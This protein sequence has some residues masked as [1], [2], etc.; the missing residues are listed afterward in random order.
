RRR[1]R[2]RQPLWGALRR[3]FHEPAGDVNRDPVAEAREAMQS[4]ALL[5]LEL[6]YAEEGLTPAER[7]EVEAHLRERWGLEPRVVPEAVHP[8]RTQLQTYRSR[9]IEH[10]AHE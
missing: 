5:L 10:F 3:A 7:L 2:G 9:I 6:A 8:E 1:Q 4:A